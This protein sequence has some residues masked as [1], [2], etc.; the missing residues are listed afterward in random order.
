M[1]KLMYITNRPE[2]AQI[3]ESAG[4]DRIFID[5]EYIGKA[6]RQ[7][8]MDTVQSHHTLQDVK[9]IASAIEQAELLVR[10]NPI[11]EAS[12]KYCSS[13]EEIEA[14]IKNGAQIIMLPYF[15]TVEEVAEF[16]EIV[17][18]RVKT[19][20]LVET[21]EAVEV[22]DDILQ[23][24]GI[25]EIYIGLN[26][27]SLGYGMKFMFE[28]LSNGTVEELCHKFHKKGIPYGFGGIAALG[29][30]QLPAEKI[31]AEHYRLGSTRAILS[32]SFCNVEK[33]NH[34]GVISSTFVNGVKE[35][36]DYEKKVAI[37]SDFFRENS[38]DIAIAVHKIC[39][40]E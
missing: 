21:P 17:D 14:A 23:L 16:L 1:L 19:M 36:R 37:H 12:D 29:K 13:R 28:L 15:K 39:D 27:L 10:V 4:V 35:M 11:H 6:E 40:E 22:I 30:G 31:I 7:G 3:A 38:E 8:G 32:R 34:M 18:G 25:D 26:D 33:V 5:M 9:N 20:P 2:I 24:D